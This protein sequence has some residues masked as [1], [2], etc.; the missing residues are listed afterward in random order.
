[1]AKRHA[2]EERWVAD[3]ESDDEDTV[4]SALH[5][6]CPCSGSAERYE[7]FMP[8]LHRFKR[9]TRPKVRAVAIHLEVDAM[10]ELAKR[11]EESVG[12]QRNKPGGNRLGTAKAFRRVGRSGRRY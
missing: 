3:L 7:A 8:V 6:A 12:Y 10:Q 2:D 4:V 5:A 1:M 9:D 11:D